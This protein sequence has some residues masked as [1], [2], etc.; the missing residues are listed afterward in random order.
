MPQ[1]L[2]AHLSQ[3]T[4]PH[5]L[6]TSYQQRLN[7][8]YNSLGDLL[9]FAKMAS[10]LPQSQ[11]PPPTLPPPPPPPPPAAAPV[12]GP[13]SQSTPIPHTAPG[14]L[15]SNN[16][17]YLKSAFSLVNNSSSPLDNIEYDI[18]NKP[19]ANVKSNSV[20]S[21]NNQTA[22][23]FHHGYNTNN[24]KQ[25]QKYSSPN[26]YRDSKDYN[27]SRFTTTS[28][29]STNHHGGSSGG[30]S[31]NNN[32]GSS[33]QLNNQ[34]SSTNKNQLNGNTNSN[35]DTKNNNNSNSKPELN[36][37]C[38]PRY[39]CEELIKVDA[40]LETKELWEKFHELGTEMII[41]KTGRR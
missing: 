21:N 37:A 16:K 1:L 34:N 4:H 9:K 38:L 10:V 35:S 41:T 24:N 7:A 28:S 25:D 2:G 19:N 5:S 12:S 36:P 18:G 14:H 22:N 11:V 27:S 30:G 23:T 15:K 8:E 32:S 40:K 26:N 31:G 33:K 17:N 20:R 3:L 39:N 29:S 13:G 6:T